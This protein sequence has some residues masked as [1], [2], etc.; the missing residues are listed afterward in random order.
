MNLVLVWITLTSNIHL[1]QTNLLQTIHSNSDFS[2]SSLSSSSKFS[3]DS[4][5]SSPSVLGRCT[6]CRL[7]T[8]SMFEIIRKFWTDSKGNFSKKIDFDYLQEQTCLNMKAG[9]DDCRSFAIE[10]MAKIQEW[11]HLNTL[12]GANS[13]VVNGKNLLDLLCIDNLNVCCPEGHYGPQCSKCLGFPDRICSNNGKC[14]G[15]GT[16][17]GNGHCICNRGYTGRNCDFCDRSFYL[18]QTRLEIDGTIQC[19]L[20]DL[21]CL[22]SCFDSGPKGCHVCKN[23]FNWSTEF[24]CLDIDECSNDLLDLCPSNS[25]CINTVGSYHCYQCDSACDGCDGDGPDSCLKCATDHILKDGVCVNPDPKPLIQPY[26]S[27]L[28]Y[29]TYLGMCIV[30]CIIFR[31]NIFVASAIGIA[32]AIYIMASEKSLE[33]EYGQAFE[34]WWNKVLKRSE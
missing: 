16:R 4:I 13:F 19:L 26:A 33:T 11:W 22:G 15:S 20:C 32:V 27:P 29:M 7:M 8:N 1:S 6:R 34:K 17:L 10:N 21:S 5:K 18:N 14:A 28:R 12:N 31:H 2:N 3:S 23:G 30:T 9:R 25:F 24:G